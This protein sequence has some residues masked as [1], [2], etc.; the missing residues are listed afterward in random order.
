[1][2]RRTVATAAAATEG[3]G[4]ASVMGAGR[5]LK[6]LEVEEGG[7]AGAAVRGTAKALE[8]RK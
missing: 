3:L 6:P 1:M 5:K 4:D 7:P 2:V 8:D